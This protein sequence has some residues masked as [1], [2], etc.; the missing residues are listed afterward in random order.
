MNAH[1]LYESIVN[2]VIENQSISIPYLFQETDA[3]INIVKE[4]DIFTDNELKILEF[5]KENTRE[6]SVF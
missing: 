2:K 4:Y 5:Y 6:N 1:Q 3:D